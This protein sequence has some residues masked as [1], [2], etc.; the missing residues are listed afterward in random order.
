[1]FAMNPNLYEDKAWLSFMTVY[2][3]F[4]LFVRW[5]QDDKFFVVSRCRAEMKKSVTYNMHVCLEKCGTIDSCE[6]ECAAGMGPNAH[7]KHIRA[8]LYGLVQL[9]SGNS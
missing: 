9:A 8:L 3:R 5:A 1:M 7:C 2:F 6:C 4:L